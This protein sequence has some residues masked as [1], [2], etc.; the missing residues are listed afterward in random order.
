MQRLRKSAQTWEN[1]LSTTGGKL[2]ISKCGMYILE[3][4]FY[5]DDT[6]KLQTKYPLQQLI[7]QSSID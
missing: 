5:L 7:I 3:Y 2:E 6:I 1:L 4:I